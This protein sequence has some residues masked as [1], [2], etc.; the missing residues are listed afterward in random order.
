MVHTKGPALTNL[1]LDLQKEFQ[2]SILN[3][4]GLKARAQR[5]IYPNT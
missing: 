5:N 2:G 1:M 3:S 4:S